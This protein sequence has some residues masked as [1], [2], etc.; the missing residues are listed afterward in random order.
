MSEREEELL[1][2]AQKVARRLADLEREL[3][4]LCAALA[5]IVVAMGK[6]AL[7]KEGATNETVRSWL[8]M[9]SML[10]SA[11]PGRTNSLVGPFVLALK[12]TAVSDML[13]EQGRTDPEVGSGQTADDIT[14]GVEGVLFFASHLRELV[15]N[16][17]SE[18]PRWPAS[19]IQ[20]EVDRRIDADVEADELKRLM[21]DL[22]WS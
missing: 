3:E 16:M 21:G 13:V 11:E 5:R 15:W 6:L 20:I 10:F 4:P 8:S 14:K 12:D 17:L 19:D 22:G 7:A 2:T 9:L 18:H 1:K